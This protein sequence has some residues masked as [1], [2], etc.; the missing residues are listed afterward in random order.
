MT[1]N[2]LYGYNSF[3]A[4]TPNNFQSL[5]QLSHKKAWG[6]YV[7]T[8]GNLSIVD[9]LGNTVIFSN[10]PN[11]TLLPIHVIGIN[12]AGT[13]ASNIIACFSSVRP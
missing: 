7:G 6:L 5:V 3:L 1:P 9:S 8:G 10:V 4:V 2:L 13:T 11:G 12:S